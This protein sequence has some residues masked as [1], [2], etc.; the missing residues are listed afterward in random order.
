[1][2]SILV[3]GCR[4]ADA[5]PILLGSRAARGKA[6]KFIRQFARLAP[7]KRKRKALKAF[8]TSSGRAADYIT[9]GLSI[10]SW[11]RY[12]SWLRKF[13]AYLQV[14]AFDKGKTRPTPR[15]MAHNGIALEFLAMVADERRGRTRAAA[16]LRA[17]NFVRSFLG[18]PRLSDDPRAALLIRGVARYNPHKPKGAVPFPV[19]AIIAIVQAWGSSPLW[20]R[21]MV[22][23]AIFLAFVAL[24]RGKGLLCIPRRGV[25]W[26]TGLSEVTNPRRAPKHHSG[27]LLLVPKRKTKQ[28]R[29]SF[30]TVKAGK[31]TKLL[32][33][34]VNWLRARRQRPRFLF[35]ARKRKYFKGKGT[36][37]PNRTRP[38]SGS[39]LLGLVR[40]A[41]RLVC[42]LSAEQARR[43]TIHSLRV[44]GINYYR[45][46]GVPLELRA[47]M[48]DHLSLP[49]S[50]R[51]LRLAPA[52]QVK[53]LS[54]IVGRR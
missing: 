13:G 26:L 34:H 51:Y 28:A 20:W 50:V 11:Q 31:V 16:A 25:T 43:Y 49:S 22:A 6:W 23:L 14:L 21:R 35:P 29:H 54:S 24:L 42:G 12:V 39:S 41:L 15:M 3:S 30:V 45:L 1:M 2:Q 40:K 27:A 53:I 33:R 44:G 7:T 8:T 48:A 38:M 5:P 36:W 19:V 32:A 47:Q 18:L 37:V 46:L 4:N 52:Q 17:I 9:A 10:D